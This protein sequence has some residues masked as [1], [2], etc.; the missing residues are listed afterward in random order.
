M[1]DLKRM[2]NQLAHTICS[3]AHRTEARKPLSQTSGLSELNYSRI[4]HRQVA[5][6][7]GLTAGARY[8][9]RKISAAHSRLDRLERAFAAVCRRKLDDLSIGQNFI[10]CGARMSAARWAERLPLKLSGQKKDFHIKELSAVWRMFIRMR[11]G[12]LGSDTAG[13]DGERS[14]K[15]AFQRSLTALRPM[16]AS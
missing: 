4:A 1:P 8:R 14:K 7:Y 9:K 16:R 15:P 5:R 13:L 10:G 12:R 6:L 11:S 2:R 3:S